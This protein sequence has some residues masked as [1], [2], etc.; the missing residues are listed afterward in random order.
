MWMASGGIP[1]PALFERDDV[2][3]MG[4]LSDSFTGEGCSLEEEDGT[5]T[6]RERSNGDHE[7]HTATDDDAKQH[8]SDWRSLEGGNRKKEEEGRKEGSRR[9]SRGPLS[10]STA[11]M[12]GNVQ[13][14][15][16]PKKSTWA[17]RS[18]S[19]KKVTEE[20][21][22]MEANEVT[23]SQ[24]VGGLGIVLDSP[25]GTEA[26][27]RKNESEGKKKPA[28]RSSDLGGFT[29]RGLFAGETENEKKKKVNVGVSSKKG[30]SEQTPSSEWVSYKHV[31]SGA[32]KTIKKSSKTNINGSGGKR[33]PKLSHSA[34]LKKSQG[35][36]HR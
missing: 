1:D 13:A 24:L 22:S 17:G 8:G 11:A 15:P 28:S 16:Q 30:D 23:L 7:E 35:P 20:V 12:Q 4:E 2:D 26:E 36:P 3:D 10:D 19:S 14:Q 29:G 31:S 27:S 9:N 32:K 34:F 5:V 18:R 6:F 33:Q 25:V 21:V